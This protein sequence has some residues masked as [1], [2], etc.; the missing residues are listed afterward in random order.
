[1]REG[2]I[3]AAVAAM[4]LL[5]CAMARADDAVLFHATDQAALKPL[6]IGEFAPGTLAR[7]GI[8]TQTPAMRIGVTGLTLEVSTGNDTDCGVGLDVSAA[9]ARTGAAGPIEGCLF[10]ANLTLTTEGGAMAVEGQCDDW[11]A[12]VSLCWIEGEAGQFRLVR[13]EPGGKGLQLQFDPYGAAEQT[14]AIALPAPAAKAAAEAQPSGRGIMLDGIYDDAGRAVSDRWLL[15]PA[16][17]VTLD[18]AR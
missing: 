7:G 9:L 16:E 14:A 4:T 17:V 8:E 6:A 11:R 3:W 18:L 5:A 12:G 15:L 10:L 1:M 13:R 2:W